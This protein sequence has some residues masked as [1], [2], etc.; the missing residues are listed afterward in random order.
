VFYE[1]VVLGRD[2]APL[3]PVGVSVSG[4]VISARFHVPVPPLSW[5]EALPAPHQAAL[6]EWRAGRGF[7]LRHGS[8]PLPIESVA[9]DGDTVRITSGT[10][11]PPGAVLGYA[12]T[13]D[14]SVAP[15][16][17]RRGGQLC[18]SD[19]MVGATT[20]QAQPNYAVAFELPLP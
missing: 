3:Q 14:G 10:D 13:S 1:R 20:G 7:E 16:R 12:V 6:T 4:R 17:A 19:P 5:D 15:N 9:I 11:L 2:W 8:T 18:D